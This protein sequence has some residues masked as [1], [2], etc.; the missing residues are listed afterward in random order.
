MLPW[1]RKK[2]PMRHA[3]EQAPKKW[4]RPNLLDLVT[5]HREQIASIYPR[6]DSSDETKTK[7][8]KAAL[9]LT[10][11]L[12]SSRQ[13]S[14]LGQAAEEEKERNWAKEMTPGLSIRP[15]F[16]RTDSGLSSI[17]FREKM[18]VIASCV[19]PASL[20]RATSRPWQRWPA[21]APARMAKLFSAPM[22]PIFDCP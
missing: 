11:D 14:S 8:P 3:Q 22:T 18:G 20:M 5:I 7:A 19:D 15:R 9:P 10:P 17:S 12:R 6:K 2:L 16:S 21:C 1:P 13:P 4:T